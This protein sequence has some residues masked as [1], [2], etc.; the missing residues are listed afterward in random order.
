[1]QFKGK[2]TNQ[3]WENDEKPSFWPD[4]TPNLGPKTFF[5]S[6]TPTRC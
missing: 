2:L 3:T 5:V 6:F 1:M 4:F